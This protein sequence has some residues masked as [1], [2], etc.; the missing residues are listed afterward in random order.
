LDKGT[1]GVAAVEFGLVLPLLMMILTGII[2]Y[3]YILSL[4]VNLTNAVR[5]GAR[6][7]IRHQADPATEAE[8]AAQQYLDNAHITADEL[9]AEL[10]NNQFLVVTTRIDV[11]PLIGFLRAEWLPSSLGARSVMRWEWANP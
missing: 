6:E 2:E 9:H 7:G 10:E 11:K 4:Q 3:G 5:E 8:S 1:R